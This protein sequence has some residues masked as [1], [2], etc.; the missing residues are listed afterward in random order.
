[1][2]PGGTHQL[3]ANYPGDNSFSPSSGNYTLVVTPA[4]AQLSSS[5]PTSDLNIVG[6]FVTFDCEV[7]APSFNVAP[8]TGSISFYDGTTLIP[9]VVTVETYTGLP[10]IITSGIRGQ[11]PG[12]FTTIGN[13][14]IT[15]KYSGDTNYAAA[16]I[17]IGNVLVKYPVTPSL[18]VSS[19]DVN[20][21]DTVTIAVTVTSTYKTPILTGTFTFT[22]NPPIPGPVT[23]VLSTDANGNQVLT[24]TVTTA[25]LP[26]DAVN[27]IYSG[28]DNYAGT[29]TGTSFHVIIPEF[30]VISG[31]PS[32][33]IN[34]GQTGTSAITVT[35]TSNIS[36]SVVLTCNLYTVAGGYLH[37]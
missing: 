11:M 29:L 26:F 6:N 14:A 32:M 8:P 16:T 23:P 21:G 4:N 25:P 18:S 12:S 2:L 28:D 10:N 27:A 24:A 3:V 33:T 34:A 5:F 36:S 30:T 7:L 13:H 35:P 37:I 19:L 1:M 31:S 20:L 9:G 22:G 15:A 17:L